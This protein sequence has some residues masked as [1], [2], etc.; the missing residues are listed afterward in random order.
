MYCLF[1]TRGINEINSL[2]LVKIWIF[3]ENFHALL[4]CPLQEIVPLSSEYNEGQ[5]RSTSSRCCRLRPIEFSKC[6][7][8]SEPFEHLLCWIV[9]GPFSLSSLRALYN[10]EI[11]RACASSSGNPLIARAQKKIALT[12]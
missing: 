6:P 5:F 4:L 8:L 9:S 10:V 12:Q 7:A 1:R 11:P 3:R 2:H